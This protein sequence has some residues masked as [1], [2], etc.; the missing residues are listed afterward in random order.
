MG[1]GSREAHGAGGCLLL[2]QPV[3]LVF[4]VYAARVFFCNGR[5]LGQAVGFMPEDDLKK[6]L[7][8]M[9]GRY[10]SCLAQSSDLR[11]YIV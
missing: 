8:S 5:P 6:T 1:T 7:N 10:R 2:A 4:Q 11:S 9:L 3:S